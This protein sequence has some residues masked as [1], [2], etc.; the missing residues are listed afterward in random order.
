VINPSIKP[1]YQSE[2]LDSGTLRFCFALLLFFSCNLLATEEQRA[3]NYPAW[4]EV[5]KKGANQP[6]YF[7]A[8]GGDAQINNY[9]QWA[10][11]EVK[12]RYQIQLHHVKLTDTAEAVSRVLAEKSANN[13]HNGQVDLVWI[14]GANFASMAKHQLLAP[15]WVQQLPN[16]SLTNPTNNPAMS[17][18]FGVPTQGMEAPWGQAA[19]TF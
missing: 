8:W 19:L 9:I 17:R 12:A 11:N 10:A 1:H 5:E 2:F 16:F 13:H 6:V 18:D 7:H 15:Q 3:L 4:Q 14:N